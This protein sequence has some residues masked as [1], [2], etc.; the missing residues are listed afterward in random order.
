MSSSFL[1]S[2]AVVYSVLLAVAALALVGLE[3]LD[4]MRNIYARPRP[5]LPLSAQQ[6]ARQLLE[7]GGL[8]DI[9][10]AT[11]QFIPD[12]SWSAL[13]D[14]EER[15]F[16]LSPTS[17]DARSVTAYASVARESSR[18]LRGK[19]EKVRSPVLHRVRRAMPWRWIV[20]IVFGLL[21][22]WPLA[23][24]L[25]VRTVA[26]IWLFWLALGVC[27][28]A[29][30]LLLLAMRRASG[31]AP[32]DPLPMLAAY[33]TPADLRSARRVLVAEQLCRLL[34]VLIAVCAVMVPAAAYW[35]ELM[36]GAPP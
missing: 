20:R 22:F 7:C 10:V 17:A 32:T 25:G 14:E 13:Y 12:T 33:L 28:L 6:L 1:M 23:T 4:R 16:A 2:F 31:D 5:D 8:C 18:A 27:A 29:G 15:L 9:T 30:A 26:P 36:Q 21:L 34:L 11:I 24:S 19:T 35:S 3:V